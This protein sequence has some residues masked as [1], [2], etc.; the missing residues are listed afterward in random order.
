MLVVTLFVPAR[1]RLGNA[2]DNGETSRWHT[3]DPN[4]PARRSGFA[5]DIALVS[6]N[7]QGM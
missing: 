6:H 3:V 7:H 1:H 4:N 5:D 2:G